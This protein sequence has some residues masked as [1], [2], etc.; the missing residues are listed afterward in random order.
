MRQLEPAA[1]V[2]FVSSTLITN[3]IAERT[4]AEGGAKSFS[5]SLDR[6]ARASSRLLLAVIVLGP[7]HGLGVAALVFRLPLLLPLLLAGLGVLYSLA[8][9]S[10]SA[11]LAPK[12]V[13]VEG[14]ALVV[15]RHKWRETRVD[16]SRLVTAELRPLSDLMRPWA[17]RRGLHMGI[18][19]KA[20]LSGVGEVTC[21][22]GGVTGQA[23]LLRFADR[24]PMLVGAADAAGLLEEVRR[25]VQLQP[26]VA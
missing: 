25:R 5:I 10:L 1:V 14:N 20:L 17:L 13:R 3:A 15:E 21:L 23:V 12:A 16:L 2:T 22:S 9:F 19:G 7:L 26:T 24:H 6:G 18:E 11:A 4:T 8:M